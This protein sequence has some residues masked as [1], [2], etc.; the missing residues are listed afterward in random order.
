MLKLKKQL[1][2]KQKTILI[3]AVILCAAAIVAGAILSSDSSA[4]AQQ[5]VTETPAAPEK[6]TDVVT[7]SGV[8]VP[9]VAVEEEEIIE[10]TSS[11]ALSPNGNEHIT[12]DF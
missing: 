1:T 11:S 2:L 7:K 6:D 4:P 9:D 5:I 10:I 8:S 12:I 3:T